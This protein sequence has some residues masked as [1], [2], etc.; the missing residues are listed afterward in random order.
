[1]SECLVSLRI[2]EDLLAEIDRR[3]EPEERRTGRS[4]TLRRELSRWYDLLAHTRRELRRQLT[5]GELW[6]V[7]A[8]TNGWYTKGDTIPITN[9]AL[10]WEVEEWLRD[11]DP[12]EGVDGPALVRKLTDLNT[13]ERAALLDAAERFWLRHSQGGAA[14]APGVLLAEEGAGAGEAGEGAPAP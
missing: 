2:P 5:P 9:P 3:S 11:Q 14:G 12:P 4:D 6:V 1:M 13:A 7:A 10:A 8:V